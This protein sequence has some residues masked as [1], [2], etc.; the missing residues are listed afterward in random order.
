MAS[1]T[2]QIDRFRGLVVRFALG[3]LT[4]SPALA[5]ITPPPPNRVEP[6]VGDRGPGSVSLRQAP[7]DLRSPAGFEG[8]YQIDRT[9]PFA[10]PGERTT[11]FFMRQ[12][13][14]VMAV[15]PRSTYA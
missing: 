9:N 4:S 11:P 12:D 5:Q 1:R 13:G 3:A 8:V 14:G 7:L 15:F 6:G 2:A 10:S